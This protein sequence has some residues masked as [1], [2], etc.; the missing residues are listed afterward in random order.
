MGLIR[1]WQRK[2]ALDKTRIDEALWQEVLAGLPFL[3]GLSAADL[4]RLRELAILFLAEKGNA[5]R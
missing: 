4:A 5:W 2:R 1:N 3:R